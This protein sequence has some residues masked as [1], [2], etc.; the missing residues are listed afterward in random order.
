MSVSA[1]FG[2]LN[3]KLLPDFVREPARVL[4]EHGR[5]LAPGFGWSGFVVLVVLDVLEDQGVSLS[6]NGHEEPIGG[7]DDDTFYTVV[8]TEHRRFLPRLDPSAF[9]GH[10]FHAAFVEA[11]LRT[12]EGDSAAAARDTV[13]ILRD[14]IATL[15]DDEA[16]IVVVG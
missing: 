7:P 3:T 1:S 11:G 4:A 5:E 8:T 14:G 9:P 6:G 13:A 10:L 2:V 12:D 16:L 15:A